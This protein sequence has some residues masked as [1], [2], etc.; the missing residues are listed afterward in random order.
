MRIGPHSLNAQYQCQFAGRLNLNLMLAGAALS[1]MDVDRASL[2]LHIAINRPARHR[3]GELHSIT[4]TEKWSLRHRLKNQLV[5]VVA[6]FIHRW[7]ILRQRADQSTRDAW[8]AGDDQPV[9]QRRKSPR[10]RR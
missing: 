2:P 9:E 1:A 10:R 6:G 8:S 4:D 7:Q 3:V 5:A